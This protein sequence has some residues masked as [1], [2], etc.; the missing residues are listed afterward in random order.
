M[1]RDFRYFNKTQK[2]SAKVF[3]AKSK[4]SVEAKKCA[5]VELMHG[6]MDGWVEGQLFDGQVQADRGTQ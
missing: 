3:S 6:W 4:Q 2:E 5:T 1:R